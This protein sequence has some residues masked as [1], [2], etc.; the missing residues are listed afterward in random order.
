MKITKIDT[1]IVGAGWRNLVFV[2][3]DTDAGI[4]GIGEASLRGKE[5]AVVAVLHMLEKRHLLGWDPFDTERLLYQIYRD[6]F[7]RGGPVLTTALSAVEIA[8]WD[9]IGKSCG[10]PVYKLLGGRCHDKIRMYANGWY[11]MAKTPEEFA[12]RAKMVVEKGYT[13]MKFDPFGLM[14][15]EGSSRDIAY[16]IQIVE[17]VR[18]AIGDDV[19]LIIEAHGRFGVKTAIDVGRRLEPSRPLWYEEPLPPENLDALAKVRAHINI[20][21]SAGERCYNKF[22]FNDLLNRQIVEV[23]QPDLIHMGGFL[24]A[25]KI[26][27][28]ADAQH[29]T[30]CP[31][32]CDGPVLTAASIHLDFC[33]N[34]VLMQEAFVDF[35]VPWMSRMVDNSVQ[36]VDGYV[37]VPEAPGL[38]MDLNTEI[39]EDFELSDN[40]YS[41]WSGDW[42]S[43][44]TSTS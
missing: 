16:S 19:D 3:V 41:C 43:R 37:D 36:I 2:K 33:T 17:A 27:A 39:F 9:I 30:V 32:N 44:L 18:K 15:R 4:T 10:Q 7:D 20:P 23:L 8:C 1:Y 34:N 5:D 29:V 12:A 35:D 11:G 22:A 24:E 38:G 21:I 13:A 26:A 31:H 42:A 28:M 14:D 6:D 25:K 40:T